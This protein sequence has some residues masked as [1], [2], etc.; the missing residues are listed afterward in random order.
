MRPGRKSHGLRNE[1]GD[2]L[3]CAQWRVRSKLL[4]ETSSER[5]YLAVT[6]LTYAESRNV[7][8]KHPETCKYGKVEYDGHVNLS[9]T[10]GTI[11]EIKNPLL[12]VL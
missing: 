3:I 10:N 12:P 7:S 9:A 4:I 1:L 5:G 2:M 11:E 8:K 6:C